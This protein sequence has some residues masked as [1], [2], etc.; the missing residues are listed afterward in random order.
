[1]RRWLVDVEVVVNLGVHLLLPGGG[2]FCYL[3]PDLYRVEEL[4]LLTSDGG[5]GGVKAADDSVDLME[6]FFFFDA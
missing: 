6:K 3:G 2:F 5:D 1:M 4:L